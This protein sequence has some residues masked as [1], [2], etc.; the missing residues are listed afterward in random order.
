MSDNKPIPILPENEYVVTR[1]IPV[2][3]TREN[4]D[5]HVGRYMLHPVNIIVKAWNSGEASARADEVHY[6]FRDK[7][8]GQGAT[9][10][11]GKL[12]WVEQDVPTG[13]KPYELR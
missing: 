10:W 2:P 1:V 12:S 8:W 3:V 13:T 11:E 7:V 9:P 4:G 6:N 5:R